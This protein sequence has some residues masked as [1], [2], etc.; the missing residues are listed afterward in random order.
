MHRFDDAARAARA[1]R[2]V[3]AYLASARDE[4]ASL[5][6]RYDDSGADE[7]LVL[8]CLLARGRVSERCVFSRRGRTMPLDG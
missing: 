1:L 6:L 5:A 4:A 8:V 2:S 7:L 3:N